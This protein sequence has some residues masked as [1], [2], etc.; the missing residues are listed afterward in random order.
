VQAKRVAIRDRVDAYRARNAVS[1]A[2]GNGVTED[3]TNAV[4]NAVGTPPPK[5]KPKPKPKTN[6]K[7][8]GFALSARQTNPVWDALLV[9]GEPTT[10][11]AKRVRGKVVAE[12]TDAAAT[13]EQIHDRIQAWPFHFDDATLTDLALAKH[14]STLA[15]PP[16]RATTQQIA[17]LTDERERIQRRTRAQQADQH[18]IGNGET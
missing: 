8:S 12:L 7:S 14:W 6:S 17:E 16:A 5:P 13:P 3:V 9:L 18:A 10:A 15:L 4:G 1:N 11:S 2:V